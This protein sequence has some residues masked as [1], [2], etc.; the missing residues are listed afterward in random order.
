MKIRQEMRTRQWA[1]MDQM[2]DAQ[3]KLQELYDGDR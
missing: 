2:M 1:L 3:D